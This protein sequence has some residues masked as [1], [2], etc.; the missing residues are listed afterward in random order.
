M[1]GLDDP[2]QLD[3]A[4]EIDFSAQQ[5]SAAQGAGVR[6]DHHEIELICPTTGNPPGTASLVRLCRQIE[7]GQS[8]SI[9][10]HDFA[11]GLSDEFEHALLMQVGKCTRN[12]LKR[13]SEIIGDIS[14]GHWQCHDSNSR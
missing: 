10:E 4:Y 1:P 13:Q 14:T 3:R 9:A 6:C 7:L 8:Y 2:N 11:L 12:R 5:D